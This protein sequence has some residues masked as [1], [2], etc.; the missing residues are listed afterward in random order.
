MH[1]SGAGQPLGRLG[2]L[3]ALLS[4]AVLAGA[5]WWWYR[6]HKRATEEAGGKT[7][8]GTAARAVACELLH[9]SIL[10]A[11]TEACALWHASCLEHAVFESCGH[12][13]WWLHLHMELCPS[14]SDD[15][16]AVHAAVPGETPSPGPPAYQATAA[17]LERDIPSQQ[18]A[19]RPAEVAGPVNTPAVPAIKFHELELMRACGEGSLGQVCWLCCEGDSR[20]AQGRVRA[21]QGDAGSLLLSRPSTAPLQVYEARWRETQVAVK[22]LR[23][24]PATTS[25]PAGPNPGLLQKVRAGLQECMGAARMG[26]ATCMASCKC[27]AVLPQLAHCVPRVLQECQ[28][29][30]NLRHPCIVS[31]L[32]V[33]LEPPGLVTEFCRWGGRGCSSGPARVLC[34]F[35]RC[36]TATMY[37]QFCEPALQ[38]LTSC[39]AWLPAPPAAGARCVTS[40]APPPPLLRLRPS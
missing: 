14:P 31:F 21:M 32:G 30:A 5:I 40:S 35:S 8:V 38:A 18:Q 37:G 20:R 10:T 4:L 23:G 24:G 22:V 17:P 39:H 19:E 1:I 36:Q 33:V 29:I 7:S 26:A 3:A 34:L 6:R 12:M 13:H 11:S 16:M 28:L 9:L 25:S 27:T 2:S 15:P